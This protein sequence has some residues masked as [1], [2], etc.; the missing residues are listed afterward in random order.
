M[1]GSSLDGLDMAHCQFD[2]VTGKMEWSI[3]EARTIPFTESWKSK[4]Q[5]ANTLQG[6]D[7]MQLDAQF[8]IFIG[9]EVKA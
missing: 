8:G 5:N 3:L 1:S 6:F 7:L 4:L 9:K 2:Q